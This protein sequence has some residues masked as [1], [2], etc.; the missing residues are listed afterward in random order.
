MAFEFV[1]GDP[2]PQQETNLPPGL[3]KPQEGT[4]GTVPE[5]KKRGRP[6][7][8]MAADLYKVVPHS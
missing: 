4:N 3:A 6:K 8:D 5:K 1:A 2:M 7:D